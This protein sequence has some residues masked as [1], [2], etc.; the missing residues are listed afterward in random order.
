MVAYHTEL[1][2]LRCYSDMVATCPV[3]PKSREPFGWKCFVREQFLL[4]SLHLKTPKSRLLFI[5]GLIHIMSRCRRRVSKHRYRI[6]LYFFQ[7]IE[8]C[9]IQCEQIFQISIKYWKYSDLT[10]DYICLNLSTLT[11]FALGW[12]M[13][14][15]DFTI[16]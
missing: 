13:A 5:F 6:F 2:V 11:K 10:N 7:L 16:P 4:A 8:L 14:S 12:S 15:T 3:F 1:S 9:E